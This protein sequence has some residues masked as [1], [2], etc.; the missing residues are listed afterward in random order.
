MGRSYLR[1]RLTPYALCP[2]EYSV[3]MSNFSIPNPHCKPPRRTYKSLSP[4]NARASQVTQLHL[5]DEPGAAPIV[6]LLCP[7]LC[8]HL[9]H[10]ASGKVLLYPYALKSNFSRV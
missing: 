5:T 2:S 8:V 4:N 9:S 7:C 10:S 1:L 6:S 3:H